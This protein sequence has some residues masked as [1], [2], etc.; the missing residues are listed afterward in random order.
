[1]KQFPGFDIHTGA[2]GI[3]GALNSRCPA[4]TPFISIKGGDRHQEWRL[5][6]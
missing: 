5:Q 1:V 4:A 2:I 6:F 3:L